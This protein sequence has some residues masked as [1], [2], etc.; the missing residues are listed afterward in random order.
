MKINL[1][2]FISEYKDFKGFVDINLLNEI[3]ETVFAII[4]QPHDIHGYLFEY[5]PQLKALIESGVTVAIIIKFIPGT[6]KVVPKKEFR[7][8]M[9][10]N[11]ETFNYT[12][13]E[14]FLDSTSLEDIC[15]L[16]RENFKF[17]II[18]K[19]G[20]F[21]DVESSYEFFSFKTG[22]NENGDF[23]YRFPS[24]QF[25]NQFYEQ[26]CSL[27]VAFSSNTEKLK[28]ELLRAFNSNHI[29]KTNN[30]VPGIPRCCSK[31]GWSHE[32][33]EIFVEA[34]MHP[35]TVDLDRFS[36]LI[37]NEITSL[38]SLLIP[39]NICSSRCEESI[40]YAR[41]RMDLLKEQCPTLITLIY[42]HFF[43]LEHSID[44]FVFEA[45]V[46]T[47]LSRLEM[48][49][50]YK[51]MVK[52]YREIQKNKKNILS[53]IEIAEIYNERRDELG[54]FSLIDNMNTHERKI[55]L[56]KEIHSL[57]KFNYISETEEYFNRYIDEIYHLL[58]IS[59][60]IFR[61]IKLSQYTCIK[62]K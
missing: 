50:W 35:D 18:Q 9:M 3:C 41:K 21:Y 46:E 57:F 45:Y 44:L 28:K 8:H 33:L 13:K 26:Y 52:M 27:S 55:F 54:D 29:F 2:W 30:K 4:E 49:D 14:V 22:I 60:N 59:L 36:R 38:T 20:D 39:Y 24:L 61:P 34:F 40:Q 11:Y 42:N 10:Q 12:N 47:Y 56:D 43:V 1:E 19:N 5:P 25:I 62:D 51:R 15:N 48:K 6:F 7:G 32:A 23:V 53:F 58:F 37:K 17:M 16:P 31:K